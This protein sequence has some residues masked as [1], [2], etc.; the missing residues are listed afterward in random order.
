VILVNI[1]FLNRKLIAEEI[2]IL[3]K[4]QPKA[5][6]IDIFFRREFSDDMD[7]PLEDALSKVKNLVLVSNVLNF[8]DNKKR[9]ENLEKSINKFNR[10]ASSGFANFYIP[11]LSED[12]LSRTTRRFSP[13]EHVLNFMEPSFPVRL[14]YI[15][16]STKTKKFL[17]R[18]N[19]T[20]II[21]FKRNLSKYYVLDW[22]ELFQKKDSLEFI[23]NKI[24]LMGFLGPD[25]A[26]PFSMDIFFTPMNT[27]YVGKSH[28]DMYGVV[29]HA[30]IISMILEQ[31]FINFI[32]EDISILMV[33][34]IIYLIMAVFRYLRYRFE[35]L[36]ETLGLFLLIG[37]LV[38]Y[39]FSSIYMMKWFN[40]SI[41]LKLLIFVIIV[42]E[43]VSESYH[44]SL[45]PLSILGYQRFIKPFFDK[46]RKV[47]K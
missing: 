21:N 33:I 23:R 2:N 43:I 40:F 11:N 28:P 12:S 27:Q 38:F 18:N 17:S 14:S 37:I 41:E 5:I 9:Y 3:N 36:Y 1:S 26:Q 42:T 45:K 39:L 15:Y 22:K 34:F 24:I 7:K 46:F 32:P 35:E 20:E 29:V 16:D 25:T 31:D 4:Y 13:K 47:R 8:N 19:E 44:G 30:N 10:F 6:G